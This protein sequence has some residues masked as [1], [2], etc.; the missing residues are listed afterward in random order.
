[1]NE[2][3]IFP[4]KDKGGG[5]FIVSNTRCEEGTY[6]KCGHF[7]KDVY[8]ISHN[9]QLEPDFIV[10]NVCV[11][12]DMYGEELIESYNTH[13][14]VKALQELEKIY[15]LLKRRVRNPNIFKN[16]IMPKY[17][18]KQLM[19]KDTYYGLLN[20]RLKKDES[21]TKDMQEITT[22]LKGYLPQ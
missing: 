3:N 7:I 20:P 1:M 21:V 17:L 13:K 14:Y 2:Y 6:C 12:K 11:N 15:N 22:I 9:S 19:F 5:Y 8:H 16:P 4:L 18:W 10:G